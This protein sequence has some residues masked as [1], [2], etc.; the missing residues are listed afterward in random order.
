MK[1]TDQGII[2]SQKNYSENSLILKVFSQ[3]HGIYRAFVSGSKS[4]KNQSIFQI[5]NLISFEWRSRNEDGL[6]QFYYVDLVKSF[7]AKIIFDRLRL[8]CCSS[9]FS[10]ID[11]CFLEREEQQDLF[12]KLHNF[13]KQISND[14]AEKKSFIASYIKLELKI[15]ETLGYGIDLSSC[16]VTNSTENLVFVSPKSARAVSLEAGEPYKNLLLKLPAFLLAENS[17]EK[18]GVKNDNEAEN[19]NSRNAESAEKELE[20]NH[21]NLANNNLQD[22]LKL[23]GYFLEKFIFAERGLRPANRSNIEL[24]LLA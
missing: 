21:K 6:G 5:G 8:S 9:L 22:G 15:L 11:S 2:I 1:F 4:K 20:E 19:F 10:I 3:N 7:T 13:L 17:I 16:V 12:N 23:S 18:R 24:A 14:A